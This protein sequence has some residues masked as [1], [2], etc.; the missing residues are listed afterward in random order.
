MALGV[1]V[2]VTVNARLCVNVFSYELMRICA[3]VCSHV[4][5]SGKTDEGDRCECIRACGSVRDGVGGGGELGWG[6]VWGI[7]V[8]M[9][10]KCRTDMGAQ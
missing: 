10:E 3:N 7:R 1:Y 2:H 4:H 5:I 8:C 6:V 9:I